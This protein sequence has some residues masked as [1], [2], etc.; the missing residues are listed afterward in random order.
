MLCVWIPQEKRAICIQHFLIHIAQNTIY[1]TYQYEDKYS[2]QSNLFS[3]YL[4]RAKGNWVHVHNTLNV[5]F[6]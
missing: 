5:I 1:S 2:T 6:M 4:R 3:V